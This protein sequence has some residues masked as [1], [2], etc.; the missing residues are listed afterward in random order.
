MIREA[1]AAALGRQ[2][3]D[4]ATMERAMEEILGGEATPAQDVYAAGV[5]LF[6][7]LTGRPPFDAQ[8]IGAVITGFVTWLNLRRRREEDEDEEPEKEPA[9]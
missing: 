3:V 7:C 4:E 8:S 5:V 6:E 1:I 2:D 9:A